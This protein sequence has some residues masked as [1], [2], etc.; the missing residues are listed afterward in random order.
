[1]PFEFPLSFQAS[2]GALSLSFTVPSISVQ[3]SVLCGHA[4]VIENRKHVD[5]KCALK[6]THRSYHRSY[7][8]L[9]LLSTLSGTDCASQD[10]RHM[11]KCV[12]SHEKTLVVYNW[13]EK[14]LCTSVRMH[15]TCT[16]GLTKM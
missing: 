14:K 9:C 13:N 6:G 1:M 8:I 5:M 15:S 16:Y 10:M 11:L 3:L 4:N 2:C 7:H 12:M